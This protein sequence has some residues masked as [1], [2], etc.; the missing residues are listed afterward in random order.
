MVNME[1]F[2]DGRVRSM[3]HRLG[4]A[5]VSVSIGVVF[6]VAQIDRSVIET[7]F[8]LRLALICAGLTLAWGLTVYAGSQLIDPPPGD[9]IAFPEGLRIISTVISALLTL[10]SLTALLSYLHVVAAVLFAIVSA[11]GAF[12]L[13]EQYLIAHLARREQRP[14]KGAAPGTTDSS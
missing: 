4:F 10:I 2:S 3:S 12:G 7:N 14:D 13:L 11:L 1:T 9:R 6:S 5:I 8:S